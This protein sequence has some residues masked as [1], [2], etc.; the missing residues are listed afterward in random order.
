MNDSALLRES[1]RVEQQQPGQ[2]VA[3]VSCPLH[4]HRPTSLP[5]RGAHMNRPW[6]P[7][8]VADYRA[9]TVHLSAAQHGA[10]LLLI[11]HYWLTGALPSDDAALARIA[12][13][14]PAEW[15]KARPTIQ[16]FFKD[17]WKHKRIDAELEQT[18]KVTAS[19][20]E[21]ASRAAIKRW[22]KDAP[23]NAPS[24]PQAVPEQCLGMPSLPSHKKDA[25]NAAPDDLER[26]L[27]ERGKEVAGKNAGGLI[28]RVL[29]A[30]SGNVA[31]A[32][33]AIEQAS[34]KQNPR[35]YLGKIA[36]GGNGGMNSDDPDSWKQ[37]IL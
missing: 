21:R 14:T 34:T 7:L 33:A 35:E 12:C 30:K 9:D 31:L 8:Y 6:M 5:L 18:A 3:P 29:K 22:S 1:V 24:I 17:G 19:Y 16:A 32:R 25:A 13:M 11:M 37:A 20:A 36:A 10:Y 23:S 28:A 2:R 26:Q 15:R 4:D 27:F